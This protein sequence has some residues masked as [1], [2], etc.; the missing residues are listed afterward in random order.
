MLPASLAVIISL[1][2]HQ[3]LALIAL[4]SSWQRCILSLPSVCSSNI[5]ATGWS[6]WSFGS[7][8]RGCLSL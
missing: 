3:L 1:H 7:G 8:P 6:Q 5:K 2:V 4:K